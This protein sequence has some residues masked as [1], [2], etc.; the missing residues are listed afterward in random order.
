MSEAQE[1]K[2]N[3]SSSVNVE[4][5]KVG[6]QMTPQQRFEALESM[7]ELTNEALTPEAKK[8]AIK[9]RNL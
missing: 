7:M 8:R 1:P 9:L 5:L 2:A 3:Y 6:L 4:Y